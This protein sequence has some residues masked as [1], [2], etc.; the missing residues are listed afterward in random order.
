MN[1]C[2]VIES[3]ESQTGRAPAPKAMDFFSDLSE[4]GWERSDL[5]IVL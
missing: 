3:G 4:N 5:N 1:R 2:D